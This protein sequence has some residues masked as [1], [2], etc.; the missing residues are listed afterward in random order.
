METSNTMPHLL[1]F[2]LVID[3]VLIVS[4]GN[5]LKPVSWVQFG[6]IC[7]EY[8]AGRACMHHDKKIEDKKPH[9]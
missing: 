7:L 6:L 1:L 8:D 9:P 2:G 5:I 4:N 3:K